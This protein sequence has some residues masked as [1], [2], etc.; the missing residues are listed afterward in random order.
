MIPAIPPQVLLNGRKVVDST[1]SWVKCLLTSAN[2]MFGFKDKRSVIAPAAVG[3]AIDDP[4]FSV[5]KSSPSFDAEIML[6]PGAHKSSKSVICFVLV[7]CA[8]LKT[9]H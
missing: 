7:A 9:Q 1:P 2:V 3:V 4:D 5:Y 8:K 6:C